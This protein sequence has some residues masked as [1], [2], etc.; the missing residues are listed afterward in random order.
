[1]AEA[2]AHA[3]RPL[4]ISHTGARAVTDHPATLRTRRSRLWPTRAAW[5]GL[6]HAVPADGRKARGE[7]LI[8]HVEHV[9]KVAGEDHVGIGT[10]NGVLPTLLDA[11]TK[12]KMDRWQQQRIDAGIASPGE[13]I[14][15]YPLVEDYNSVDR[16]RPSSATSASAAGASRGWRS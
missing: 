7:D 13:A 15:V 2:A 6:F 10:D 4:V 14:G 12:A 3:K 16:Y 8:A 9:A 5:S 1:M 11:A